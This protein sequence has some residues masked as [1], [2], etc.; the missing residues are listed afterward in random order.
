MCWTFVARF[1]YQVVIPK[2]SGGVLV[3]GSY[4]CCDLYLLQSLVPKDLIKVL[5]DGNPTV[6]PAWD[7]MVCSFPFSARRRWLGLATQ[8]SLAWW[9]MSRFAWRIYGWILACLLY[10]RIEALWKVSSGAWTHG[11]RPVS[12]VELLNWTDEM[13]DVLSAWMVC[14][15]LKGQG[16]FC[17][18]DSTDLTI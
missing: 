18:I 10:D 15:R 11:I 13:G 1:V 17:A 3:S 9:V 2:V 14:S 8:G 6:L 7:P 4:W 5:D 12:W 16:P